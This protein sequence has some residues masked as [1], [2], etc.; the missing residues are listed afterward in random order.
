[1]HHPTN[2]HKG[3]QVPDFRAPEKNLSERIRD[4]IAPAA[5]AFWASVAQ[6]LPETAGGDYHAENVIALDEAMTAAV[7]AWYD[8]NPQ[9][10]A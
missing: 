6:A 5:A 8:E 1:M 7:C 9:A 10:G 2:H 3:A 4:A